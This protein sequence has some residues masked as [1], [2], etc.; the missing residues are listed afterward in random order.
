MNSEGVYDFST[1]FVFW[2]LFGL[3][4]IRLLELLRLDGTPIEKLFRFDMGEILRWL[5]ALMSNR[6]ELKVRR[7]IG[8]LGDGIQEELLRFCGTKITTYKE[9]NR[10][11]VLYDCRPEGYRVYVKDG[12]NT[13]QLFPVRRDSNGNL[14]YPTYTAEE[15]SELFPKLQRVPGDL[16]RQ[17]GA[18][19]LVEHHPLRHAN[20]VGD[21]RGV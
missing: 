16:R 15:V 1:F 14:Q 17:Q 6:N 11:F 8:P 12:D 7:T 13:A 19:E 20:V 4:A 18:G 5:E 3:G 10:S 9:G 21:G 2:N